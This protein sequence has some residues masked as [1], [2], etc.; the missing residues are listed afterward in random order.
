MGIIAR[1]LHLQTAGQASS[2]G[3]RQAA[4]VRANVSQD[5]VSDTNRCE[6]VHANEQRD[7]DGSCLHLSAARF[8]PAPAPTIQARPPVDH[9]EALLTWLQGPGGRSGTIWAVDLEQMHRDLC[10]ELGWETIGWIA[11]G[12]ELRRMLGGKKEYAT[13]GGQRRCVYRIPPA[14]VQPASAVARLRTLHRVA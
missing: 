9:A 14:V 11:V 7:H 6:P 1:T 8:I 13:L 5:R 4:S 2:F 3:S 12:R 10:G